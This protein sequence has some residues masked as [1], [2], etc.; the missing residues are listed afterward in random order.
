MNMKKSLIKYCYIIITF[1]FVSSCSENVYEQLKSD[2][3]AKDVLLPLNIKKEQDCLNTDTRALG[4][5]PN[6]GTELNYKIK[7]YW[8]LEYDETGNLIVSA[9]KT[10]DDNADEVKAYVSLKV[11]KGEETYQ[12]VLLANT[13]DSSFSD[14][15]DNAQTIDGL[16]SYGKKISGFNSLYNSSD[17]YMN[18]VVKITKG[19]TAVSFTAHRNVAKLT[20]NLNNAES[21]DII[22]TSVQ[23]RN[24][25][26]R[27][28]YADQLWNSDVETGV[29]PKV[30]D[31]KYINFPI[32]H[33]YIQENENKSFVYY[34]PRNQKGTIDNDDVKRKNEKAPET[35]TFIEIYGINKVDN[36]TIKYCFYPGKDMV[37]DFNICPNYHY[38][39]P[40][41]LQAAGDAI[42]D[43]RI[44]QFESSNCYMID[45]QSTQQIHYVPINR[46]NEFWAHYDTSN[47]I[48]TNTEWTADI[49]WSD[50]TNLISFCEQDGTEKTT[51]ISGQGFMPIPF[52]VKGNEGNALIGVKKKGSNE[53]LWSWHLWITSYNP[54]E[55]SNCILDET[56]GDYYMDRNLGAM[57]N[58]M[59]PA[60]Y[61]FFYQFGRKDPI[62]HEDLNGYNHN[63]YFTTSQEYEISVKYPNKYIY[64]GSSDKLNWATSQNISSNWNNPDWNSNN[65]K[66][67]F[68]PSP[69]G[70]HVPEFGNM[71][72]F[73]TA[74]MRKS[75]DETSITIT[76]QNGHTSYFAYT[77]GHNYS[78]I[79]GSSDVS[80]EGKHYVGS[81][82]YFWSNTQDAEDINAARYMLYIEN[83]GSSI[84]SKAYGLNIRCVR[85]K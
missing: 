72:A 30:D 60:A 36:S 55:N 70:W 62:P 73:F 35:A 65:T 83:V 66:S 40:I 54:D 4:D 18:D 74:N 24:I 10:V 33:V 29:S 53:Y 59:N 19:T 56:T 6:E 39:L 80:T 71:S 51:E 38:T 79:R 49:I 75:A 32:D 67:I 68:D 9:Y 17:L 12:C 81:R 16:K 13:H 58:S 84:N 45:P 57:E 21:S 7:D 27:L 69:K 85:D 25:P 5:L 52:K 77:G 20:L 2:I 43:S 64:T 37:S 50:S 78:S 76:D 63:D 31:C 22:I 23:I 48:Q 8:L 34:L 46:I 3:N 41:T 61:G 26:E 14:L 44:E 47:E 1:I 42:T 82:L 15:L 11:P 28:I